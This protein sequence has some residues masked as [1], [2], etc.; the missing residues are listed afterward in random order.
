M[1]CCHCLQHVVLRQTKTMRHKCS[2]ISRLF[3]SLLCCLR[4]A[5]KSL[6]DILQGDNGR[7]G[8]CWFVCVEHRRSKRAKSQVWWIEGVNLCW[9]SRFTKDSCQHDKTVTWRCTFKHTP[10]DSKEI[11]PCTVLSTCFYISF[12][13]LLY[14]DDQPLNLRIR[15][16]LF[17]DFV[18]SGGPWLG[19][20]VKVQPAV[21]H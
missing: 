19:I 2:L 11:R 10:T 14:Q 21:V 8:D 15:N 5:S 9:N 6:L 1:R 13:K 20:S 12:M 16:R 18:C 4:S 7:Q 3:S 17:C